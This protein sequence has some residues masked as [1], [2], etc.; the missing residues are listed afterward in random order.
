MKS[1]EKYQKQ[2][3]YMTKYKGRASN[4]K[5]AFIL[6]IQVQKC[7]DDRAQLSMCNLWK[8]K[9]AEMVQY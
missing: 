5:C 4:A 6:K 3:N 1:R 7:N 2:K 8:N 9:C